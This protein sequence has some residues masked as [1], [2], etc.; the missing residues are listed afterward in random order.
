MKKSTYIRSP[1]ISVC[2][3]DKDGI[4]MGCYRSVTEIRAWFDLDDKTKTEIL[5]Q[6]EKRKPWTRKIKDWIISHD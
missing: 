1:C 3:L 5:N 4:C 2:K 6:I